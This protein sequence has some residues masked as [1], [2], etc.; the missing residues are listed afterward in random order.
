MTTSRALHLL[1][2]IGDNSL[3]SGGLKKCSTLE[4]LS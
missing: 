3:V 1:E 2:L 4:F